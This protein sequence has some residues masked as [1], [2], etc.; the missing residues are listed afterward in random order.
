VVSKQLADTEV[1][2]MQSVVTMGTGTKAQIPGVVIAGKTGTTENYGDA[3]FIAFTDKYT[4][5]VWVG[6]PDSTKSMRTDY[7]GA[8][9]EGGTYPAEIWRA[10]MVSAIQIDQQHLAA[11]RQRKGLGTSTST[12]TIPVTSPSSAPTTSGA[13]TSPST[14]GQTPAPA[15]PAPTTT[16]PAGGGGTTTSPSSTGG[17]GAATGGAGA[18]PP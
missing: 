9:V 14:G 18:G 6:Y 7:G 17:A 16:A 4:V 10:F 15:A 2:I 3:W 5:A 13:T 1:P 11:E 12:T 8:P